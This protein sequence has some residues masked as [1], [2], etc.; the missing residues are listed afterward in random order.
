M[1]SNAGH[2]SYGDSL[3]GFEPASACKP[4]GDGFGLLSLTLPTTHAMSVLPVN[5]RPPS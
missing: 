1:A 3:T 2:F 4:V 5:Y